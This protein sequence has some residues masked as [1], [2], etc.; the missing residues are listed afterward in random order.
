MKVRKTIMAK[1][2]FGF[3]K[4]TFFGRLTRDVTLETSPQG[5]AYCRFDLAFDRYLGRD[6]DPQT[7]YPSFVA[8][9]GTAE[10]IAK[11]FKKGSPIIIEAGYTSSKWTREGEETPR[12][13]VEFEVQNFYFVEGKKDGASQAPG[14]AAPAAAPAVA[15]PDDF[16]EI[17]GDD[18]DL[19]F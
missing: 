10:S 7:E 13:R 5:H 8:W 17:D 3:G 18:G 19:P 6:K 1:S 16:T 11:F 4:A 2:A 12:V 9:R 15:P 14:Q